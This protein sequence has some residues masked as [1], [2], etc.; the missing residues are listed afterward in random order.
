MSH[1]IKG[2]TQLHIENN[3]TISMKVTSSIMEEA[4]VNPFSQDL[5]SLFLEEDTILTGYISKNKNILKQ[6]K[7]LI[8]D[9][10]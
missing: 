9:T 3:D 8:E 1:L 6:K 7:N 5:E 2:M 4:F 10:K